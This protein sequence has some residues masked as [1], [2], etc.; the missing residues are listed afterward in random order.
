MQCN[1]HSVVFNVAKDS[2]DWFHLSSSICVGCSSEILSINNFKN[3]WQLQIIFNPGPDKKNEQMKKKMNVIQKVQRLQRTFFFNVLFSSLY[4]PSWM[5][6]WILKACIYRKERPAMLRLYYITDLCSPW[7]PGF[8]KPLCI[9][10]QWRLDQRSVWPFHSDAHSQVSIQETIKCPSGHQ[11]WSACQN[12]DGQFLPL[13]RVWRVSNSL[14]Q[15]QIND[16]LKMCKYVHSV[17]LNYEWRHIFTVLLTK[18]KKIIQIICGD[19]GSGLSCSLI[20]G[21][22]FTYHLLQSTCPLVLGQDIENYRVWVCDREGKSV[23]W[24]DIVGE[25][26]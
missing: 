26:D 20:D 17:W 12:T 1:K 21:G 22:W 6:Q 23:L 14:I 9:W 16:A 8:E 7:C 5:S 19:C 10:K 4:K 25:Y 2:C 11:C 13:F 18:T 15:T 24:N 3:S